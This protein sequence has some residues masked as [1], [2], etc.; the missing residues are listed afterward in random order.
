[1]NERI[2][3]LV[4]S[5]TKS[6]VQL[7]FRDQIAGIT[8]YCIEPPDLYRS[9]AVVGGTKDP[10]IQKIVELNPT[11]LFAN[12]EEN[13]KEAIEQIQKLLPKT[14]LAL[15]EPREILDSLAE[16]E[17]I[18]K[19]LGNTPES[20]L[21]CEQWQKESAAVSAEKNLELAL[22]FI[23][24]E[25]YFVAG[26]DTYISSVLS[27]AGFANQSKELRY[28][29]VDWDAIPK[30]CHLFFTSEPYAFK[31]RHLYQVWNEIE[32]TKDCSFYLA[33]GRDFSWHG[34]HALETLKKI[35]QYQQG[36]PHDLFE[37]VVFSEA[38]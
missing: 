21:F 9:A 20:D 28:P 32:Q 5:T 31:K 3:S 38:I 18:T 7:G 10:D 29:E 8:L 30:G 23:W 33:D 26:P 2:V 36:L 19:H 14:K 13:T 34:C 25:P 1:M 6:L 4:P 16:I 15:S 11:V 37:Q 17:L 27:L 24:R 35:R 12:Y 22:Y